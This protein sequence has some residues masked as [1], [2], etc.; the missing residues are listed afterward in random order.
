MSSQGTPKK[1]PIL[2]TSGRWKDR[3]DKAVAPSDANDNF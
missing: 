3:G 2:G 1:I